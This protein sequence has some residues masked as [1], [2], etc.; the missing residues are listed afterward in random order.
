MDLERFPK[1]DSAKRMLTYVTKG[2]Y[3]NSYVGKWLYEVMGIEL[4]QAQEIIDELPYQVFVE[5]ATWGLAYHEIKWGLPVRESL[6]YE[7]RRRLIYRKRDERAPMTPYRMEV[8]LKN[9]TGREAHVDDMSGPVNTFTVT[10]DPGESAV[11]V[12]GAIRR[13]K[14]V[15][16]SHTTFTVRILAFTQ[17][18]IGG[19][20]DRYK[21]LYP[22][23]GTVPKVSTGLEL[24][25]AG[26]EIAPSTKAV[27]ARYPMA[28]NSGNAGQ[29]PK[30]SSGM[31]VADG[32]IDIT[33]DAAGHYMTFP[34]A[35]EKMRS[36]I[37]PKPGSQAVCTDAGID[38]S[39]Q[40]SG[41]RFQSRP[42]GTAPGT[43]S[44]L[45]MQTAGA[46]IS[47]VLEAIRER[48]PATGV[49]GE[50][51]QH[52]VTSVK[53]ADTESNLEAAVSAS[54]SIYHGKPS[55]TAPQTSGGLE[56]AGNGVI[57]EVETECYQVQYRFCGD[58]F[59]L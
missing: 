52:P 59:G 40:A 55:G 42:S 4:D 51:G 46:E 38:V 10:L 53:A 8:I 19:K 24:R 54:G 31:Q 45:R 3:D 2:W 1:S 28:G 5:T 17:I 39:P 11:D 9:I 15:K 13:L 25:D 16:Q 7:E 29:Y 22:A 18:E 58:S 27:Y 23:C 21:V 36:G 33:A 57:P 56:Q 44:G 37:Y 49:S 14:E 20:I 12:A 48:F 50:T 35:D 43:S 47:P 30:T 32:Q 34:Y 26:L 6:P 41:D